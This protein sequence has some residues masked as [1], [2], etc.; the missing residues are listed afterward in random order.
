MK[1]DELYPMIKRQRR[2]IVT[3]VYR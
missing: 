1:T 3:D 2:T